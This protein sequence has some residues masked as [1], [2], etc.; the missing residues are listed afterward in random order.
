L[1]G[2]GESSGALIG[3]HFGNYVAISVLGEGGMGTV[4]LAVHPGIGRQVAIKVLRPE[5]G[6]DQDLLTRFLNEARAANAIRHPNIIEILDSGVTGPGISYLVM[7]LLEGESLVARL[8]RLGWLQPADAIEI[9]RQIAS[10]LGAA[11]AKKIVHRDLKPDNLFL[12]PAPEPT[13]PTRERVKVLDFGI[14]KLQAAPRADSVRTRTGMLMGTPIYMSPEQCLG[15]RE[16]DHRTD[17]YA[18]GVILFEMLTGRPPFV[19]EGFG[20]LVNLHINRAPPVPST[21]RPGLPA[22]LDALVLKMLA[23]RPE[24]R[25]A[26]MGELETQLISLRGRVTTFRDAGGMAATSA[27]GAVMPAADAAPSSTTLSITAGERA[28]PA[29]VTRALSSDAGRGGAG[30]S[31]KF[32]ALAAAIVVLAVGG[33]LASRRAGPRSAAVAPPSAT[34]SPRLEAPLVEAKQT[35]QPDPPPLPAAFVRLR[36]TSTPPGARIVR[37]ADGAV[38]GTTPELLEVRSSPR[39]LLLRLEKAGHVPATR[40]LPADHDSATTVALPP[41]PTPRP[42][43]RPRPPRDDEP[44]KL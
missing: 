34:T 15:T 26:S 22:V 3:H 7:E 25:I 19:S 28:A 29:R 16:V 36:I 31:G 44:A 40:E 21:L 1:D 41:A 27:A 11:H 18:L 35:P 30:R 2:V 8:R 37:V 5:L 32:V 12:I 9:A 42:H 17:I 20:E 24:D 14:A 6:K 38:L 4:Y 39:P 33:L 43:P 10:A 13:N 23:K